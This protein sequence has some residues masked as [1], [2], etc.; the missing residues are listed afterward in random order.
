MK[1]FILVRSLILLAVLAGALPAGSFTYIA[2][3][4]DSLSD[5]GNLYAFSGGAFPPSPPYYAGRVSNGPVAVEYMAGRLGSPLLDYAFAGAT[6]GIG[7]TLDDGSAA[8][9]GSAGLPG[10][11]TV[12]GV[13]KPGLPI[14]PDAL[15]VVWGGPNDMIGALANPPSIPG[16][17]AT[18]VGNLD[19]IITDLLAGGAQH[20]LVPGMPD[21]GITP[22]VRA[23]GAGAQAGASATTQAFN[24]A[25]FGSLP[26]GVKF[27]DTAAFLA[28][29]VNNPAAFG[30]ANVTDACF[31]GSTVCADPSKYLFWDDIHPTTAGHAL[32][33]DQFADSVP[34]PAT[35]CLVL[36]GIL[37]GLGARRRARN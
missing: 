18:A 28:A 3:F 37:A 16:A 31:T 8:A 36:A 20:I 13:V 21:L 22:R 14:L 1:N 26:P 34:E 19:A 33:G 5:N 24:Q 7:N 6:T 4:G 32:L 27:Y 9:I 15:Y 25:L 10:M 11:S 17:I 35:A 29:I 2:V 12:Y 30:F 23:L